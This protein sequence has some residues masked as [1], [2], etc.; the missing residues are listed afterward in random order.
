MRKFEF[1]RVP[2]ELAQ[3][4]ACF[5]SLINKVFSSLGFAFK[6][7]DYILTFSPDPENHLKH[8][9]I[10]FQHFLES[11]LK[12]KEIRCN[13]EKPSSIFT[14]PFIWNW[15]LTS[16]RKV[17]K[18]PKYATS[19]RNPKEVKQ[20][21]GLASYHQTFV[22]RFSDISWPLTSLMKKDISFEW[23]KTRHNAFNLLKKYLSKS[24]IL[25]YPDPGKPYTL[26]TD[27]SKH[28]YTCVLTQTCE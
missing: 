24:P 28:T 17:E 18:P 13:F 16:H 4:P 6:Y 5:Q 2:I 22:L 10:V 23:T 1:H 7:L 20:C 27:A 26:F 21:L 14:S 25:R 9:E 3:A 19:P 11:G 12:L 15:H 8:L